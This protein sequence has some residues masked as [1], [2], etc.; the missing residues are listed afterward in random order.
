MPLNDPPERR[1]NLSTE[2][3]ELRESL[4]ALAGAVATTFDEDRLRAAILSDHQRERRRLISFVIATAIVIVAITVAGFLQ[5]RSN[6]AV[7]TRIESCTI[8]GGKCFTQLT[9]S[10]QTGSARLMEFFK[11][12]LLIRPDD[13][14]EANIEQCRVRAIAPL[15]GSKKPGGG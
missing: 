13:R 3:H 6:R 7:A 12:T 1:V 5:A 15:D 11:C 8:V 4:D 14:T 9:T 10:G 2:L